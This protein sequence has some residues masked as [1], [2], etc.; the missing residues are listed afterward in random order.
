MIEYTIPKGIL[1]EIFDK[2]RNII[3]Y[4]EYEHIVYLLC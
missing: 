2:M 4:S 3:V 1:S